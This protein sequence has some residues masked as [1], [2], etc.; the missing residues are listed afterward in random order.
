MVG[1]KRLHRYILTS[2]LP[3]FLMTFMISNFILVMQLLWRYVSDIMGKGLDAD[4][5]LQFFGYAALSLLPTSL[6][7]AVLLASLMTFGNFGEKLELLAMK[8]AGISLFNIMK[9]LIVLMVLI[10]IGAFYFQDRVNPKVQVKLVTLLASFK[11][12]SP[13]LSIPQ[14][15]FYSD[16]PGITLYVRTKDP[17]TK[18][19]KNIMIYDF[20]NGYENAAVTMADM[21]T[22]KFTQDKKHLVFTLHEGEGFS[23]FSGQ[24]T[25][26]TH[27]PYRRESFRMKQLIIDYDA[28]FNMV[29]ESNFSDSHISKNIEQLSVII[30]SVGGILDSLNTKTE[31][32]FIQEKYMGRRDKP[33]KILTTENEIRK[34]PNAKPFYP[35][36]DKLIGSL[37]KRALK[38]IIVAANQDAS[39]TKNEIEFA[40]MTRSNETQQFRRSSLE[41]YRKFTLSFACII[42]F[43]IGAPLG[44]IIRKGGIGVSALVS[45]ILFIIYYM[46]DTTGT[47]FARNGVW[48]PT[49]GGWLSTFV[50]FPLGLF[51]TYKAVKDSVIL[52]GE[53]Y[54]QFAKTW[55]NPKF[56]Y[57]YVLKKAHLIKNRE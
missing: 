16:I 9:P 11:Q 39:N 46:I 35:D 54:I 49:V 37:D 17:E 6:P 12:K 26:A 34:Q 29:D 1:I 55:L 2:F 50:L 23:N 15:A 20:S 33:G 57:R 28:N 41:Y 42:F 19:L 30:D 36:I 14:G 56:L 52:N 10:S 27:V 25:G 38:E 7:L 32:V 53:A 3:V 24:Q 47:R 18:E 8:A 44:A 40:M 21:A 31:H 13:E 43:F 48:D 45:V 51:L 4:L 22:L 5:F